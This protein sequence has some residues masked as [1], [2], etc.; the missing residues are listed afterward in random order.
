MHMSQL[1]YHSEKQDLGPGGVDAILET[2][3]KENASRYLT[4]LLMF[5]RNFFLQCLEG[6][7]EAVT[8]TFCKI[9]ADPRHANV[10]LIS[11]RQ[12]DARDFPDWTMGYIVSTSEQMRSALLE[13]QPTEEFN[14]RLLTSTSAINLM[15]RMRSLELTV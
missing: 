8:T 12:I 14:P 4:G 7:R 5:N 1:I 11:V 13:F 2:A 10:T 3:R 15:K 6:G 9:A